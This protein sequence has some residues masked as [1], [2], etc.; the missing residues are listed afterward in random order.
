M[1]CVNTRAINSSTYPIQVIKVVIYLQLS[2]YLL[3]FEARPANAVVAFIVEF[4]LDL[5]LVHSKIRVPPSPPQANT[6]KYVNG[7]GTLL[8]ILLLFAKVPFALN[9]VH[10][11]RHVF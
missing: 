8:V 6:I 2:C 7:V 5:L 9:E 3:F 10:V 11:N 4:L 1:M